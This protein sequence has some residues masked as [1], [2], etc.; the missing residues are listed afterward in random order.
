MHQWIAARVQLSDYEADWPP[1]GDETVAAAATTRTTGR[2]I[3]SY[4][5]SL[6]YLIPTTVDG[7]WTPPHILRAVTGPL[8]YVAH[9]VFAA[10]RQR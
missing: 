9:Q 8:S 7:A 5:R 4:H 3:I 2:G 1:R 10:G 6:L